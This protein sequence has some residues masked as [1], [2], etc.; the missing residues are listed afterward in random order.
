MKIN[1]EKLLRTL[2]PAVLPGLLGPYLTQYG[3]DPAQV[4][5][6]GMFGGDGYA[7]QPAGS[8]YAKYWRESA[9]G[10]LSDST[11]RKAVELVMQDPRFED[12]STQFGDLLWLALEAMQTIEANKG[13]GE[14]VE[15]GQ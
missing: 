3:I 1:V 9:T 6:S 7:G 15:D 8:G 13:A 2:G 14:V 12:L 4:D 11:V 10:K 5:L